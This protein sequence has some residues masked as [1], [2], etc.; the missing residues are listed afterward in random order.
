MK[1][2]ISN[3]LKYFEARHARRLPKALDIFQISC[4]VSLLILH[5]ASSTLYFQYCYRNFPNVTKDD[6]VSLTLSRV[7]YP[8][9]SHFSLTFCLLS[10]FP[11]AKKMTKA[12]STFIRLLP[13]IF[14]TQ[15]VPLILFQAKKVTKGLWLLAAILSSPT[16]YARV[17]MEVIVMMYHYNGPHCYCY[18]YCQYCSHRLLMQG[19][20]WRS[21]L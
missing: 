21:L 6:K 18:C 4:H 8:L 20:T 3:N 2:G 9:F 7:S 15:I 13:L 17:N 14:S 16:A 1:H 10:L 12:S 19:S 5:L 11:R